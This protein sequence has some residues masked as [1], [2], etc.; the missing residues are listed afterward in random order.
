MSQHEAGLWRPLSG[1][2]R[3]AGLRDSNIFVLRDTP[4]N[5]S[6]LE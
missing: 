4:P 3:M 2:E 5:L 6:P 1:E